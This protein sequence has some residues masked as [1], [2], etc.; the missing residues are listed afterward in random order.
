VALAHHACWLGVRK[1][2]RNDI[3]SDENALS[4]AQRPSVREMVLSVPISAEGVIELCRL[5]WLDP[6]QLRNSAAVD[7]VIELTNAAI[8]LRLRPNM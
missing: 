1:A 4:P 2:H 7:A 8:A 6:N 5:G 3:A